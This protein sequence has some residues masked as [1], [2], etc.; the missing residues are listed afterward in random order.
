MNCY[1]EAAR[2]NWPGGYV[3]ASVPW[4]RGRVS[5]LYCRDISPWPK[6]R[7]V[8]R[9][10]EILDVGQSL[11]NRNVGHPLDF[12]DISP[13]PETVDIAPPLEASEIAALL[14]DTDL[15]TSADQMCE[16]EFSLCALGNCQ[17]VCVERNNCYNI[18][19]QYNNKVESAWIRA[20]DY[21][22]H[23]YE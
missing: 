22:C 5:S 18:T 7:P 13:M 2:V 1:G 16:L 21:Y 4:M 6:N 9:G 19:P 20:N 8:V 10:H 17:T 12:E 15:T 3:D 14:E 23:L 11:E